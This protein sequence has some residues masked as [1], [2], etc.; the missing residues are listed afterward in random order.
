MDGGRE[1]E[2]ERKREREREEIHRYSDTIDIIL[3]SIHQ[4]R[5]CEFTRVQLASARLLVIRSVAVCVSSS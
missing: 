2:R 1:R 5:T 3:L 4:P